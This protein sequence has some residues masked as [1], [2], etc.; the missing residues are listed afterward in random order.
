MI[1]KQFKK[2]DS[3]RIH[4]GL[5]A[6]AVAANLFGRGVGWRHHAHDCARLIDWRIQVFDLLGNSKIQQA[7]PA[8]RLYEN[9]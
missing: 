7:H 9:I 6:Y 3:Q 1:R 4:I 2:N 5:Y 8:V